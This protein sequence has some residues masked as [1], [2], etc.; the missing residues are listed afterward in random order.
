VGNRGD[1]VE[2]VNPGDIIRLTQGY[3]TLQKQALFVKA[4]RR[5]R[6]ERIGEYVT[7]PSPATAENHSRNTELT[8]FRGV[9]LLL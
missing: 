6:I 4:G 7:P 8:G 5:G 1:E 2:A 3:F 9:V